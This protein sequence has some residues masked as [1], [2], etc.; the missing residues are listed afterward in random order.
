MIAIELVQWRH[1][2]GTVGHAFAVEGLAKRLIDLRSLSDE[3]KLASGWFT[4]KPGGFQRDA[5][6]LAKIL[7]Y[8]NPLLTP[9]TGLISDMQCWI[10]QT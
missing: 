2:V 10:L 7:I 3:C 5:K 8:S 1:I 9:S 4:S 6:C